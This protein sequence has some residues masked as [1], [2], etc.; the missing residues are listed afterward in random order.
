VDLPEWTCECTNFQE[1]KSPCTHGIAACRYASLDPFKKF[2]AYHKLRVY[3]DTYSCFLQPISIQDLESNP[4][5]HPPIIQKQRGRPK[6]KRIHKGAMK[7]R[8]KTYS[9][10]GNKTRYDKSS[11]RAQPVDNGWR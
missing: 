1:Y 10:Y 4:N 7:R 8:P 2:L 11:C 9:T 3:R 6:S 5:I